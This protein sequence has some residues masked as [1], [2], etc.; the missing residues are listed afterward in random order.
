MISRNS[1]HFLVGDFVNSA[2]VAAAE[3][4]ADGVDARGDGGSDDTGDDT[5]EYS[6]G[7][8]SNSASH[9]LEIPRNETSIACSNDGDESFGKSIALG[10][11]DEVWNA[12]EWVVAAES[13]VEAESITRENAWL[14]W[15]ANAAREDW[16]RQAELG[17]SVA[18]LV[19][20]RLLGGGTLIRQGNSGGA[21][22]EDGGG[23]EL[24]FV[25]RWDF[26]DRLVFVI[27]CDGNDKQ[28]STLLC[29][30]KN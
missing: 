14:V 18:D 6:G 7:T 8:G 1:T 13:E 17:S 11:L 29:A 20:T 3:S 19:G 9:S 2:L 25:G 24:H 21:G 22:D 16:F 12:V 27:D 23:G 15:D 28:R 5:T 30:R 26:F 4:L 10:R